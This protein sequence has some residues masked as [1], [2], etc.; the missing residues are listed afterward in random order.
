MPKI[1]IHLEFL[2]KKHSI[3]EINLI[4]NVISHI[5]PMFKKFITKLSFLK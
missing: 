2:K 4:R 5:L 1:D 3:Y